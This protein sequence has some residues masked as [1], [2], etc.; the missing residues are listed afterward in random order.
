MREQLASATVAARA[1]LPVRF[2]FGATFLYAGLDKL[3]DPSFLDGVSPT[4]LAAQLTDFARAS[5]LAPIVRVGESFATPL[6][7]LIAF[8]EIAIGLGAL[9]GL[10]YRVAAV[11]GFSPVDPL[12]AD[13]VVGRSGP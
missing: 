12:L 11:G 10:A 1:L 4:S 6:G 13:R 5:P 9:T 2:F 7:L 8:L 3:L